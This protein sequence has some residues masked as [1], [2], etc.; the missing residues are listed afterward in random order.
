M[1]G[2]EVELVP[3]LAREFRL[4]AALSALDYDTV[5]VDCPPSL[6]LLTV[7]AL[8]AAD[9]VLIPVQC[10][11]FALEGLAQ[12]L[13]TI[14]A[15]RLRLNPGVEV[16]AIVLTMMDARNRLSIQVIEEVERHFPD[17]VARV[18]IPRA[19]RLAEAPSHGKPISI[20]DPTS[21]AARAYADLAQE[22]S[23]RMAARKPVA[24]GAL[25]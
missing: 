20:Y 1:A 16:L 6:G 11:F 2:A 10:E 14:D 4:K 25:N 17:L 7:N 3:T 23:A 8:A 22:L 9:L 24:V 13:T 19:V 21:R 5:L 12:L 15:V 18:R